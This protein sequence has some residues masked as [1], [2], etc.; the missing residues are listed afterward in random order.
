MK[1]VS[2]SF[3]LSFQI[4]FLSFGP[5]LFHEFG[6]KVVE[7]ESGLMKQGPFSSS[8]PLREEAPGP[9]FIHMLR[10]AFWGSDLASKNQKNVLI[11]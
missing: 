11:E 2:E 10:G 7:F 1:T 4:T 8:K 3:F 9:P 5:S 6:F